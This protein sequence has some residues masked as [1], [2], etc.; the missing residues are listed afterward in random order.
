MGV[1]SSSGPAGLGAAPG[2]ARQERPVAAHSPR[3]VR[4]FRAPT[5]TGASVTWTRR[6]GPPAHGGA[7]S[8]TIPTVF[9]QFYLVT[10][11]RSGLLLEPKPESDQSSAYQLHRKRSP[12]G[13]GER[14]YSFRTLVV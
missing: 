6:G 13:R 12:H 14:I 7:P 5:S 11:Q 1:G 4:G 3:W 10:S 8:P 9:L 2:A